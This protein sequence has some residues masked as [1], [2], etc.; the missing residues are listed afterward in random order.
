MI[1]LVVLSDKSGQERL[2]EIIYNQ[3]IFAEK[4]YNLI[5][6]IVSADDLAPY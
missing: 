4:P 1:L 3:S 5:V 6:I 2:L